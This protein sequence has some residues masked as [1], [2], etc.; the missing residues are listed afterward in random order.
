[1][2]TLVTYYSETGNTHKIAQA[3]H[4][5]ISGEKELLP[6]GELTSLEGYGLIFFGF[7]IMQ[8]GPPRKIRMF[9]KA[10]AAGKTIALFVTHASWETPG[11]TEMLAGWLDKCKAAAEGA[12]L[13]G[14]FHCRGE[15]SAVSAAQFLESDIP[16]IRLFGSMQPATVGHPDAG[17][18]EE[19]GL[20]ARRVVKEVNE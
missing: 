8:F 17:E 7:P 5:E 3:I 13:A 9:L 12:N 10:H 6:F 4:G 14:F 11:Q 1:M 15:L 2:K 16:E 20:F 18:L 19:A